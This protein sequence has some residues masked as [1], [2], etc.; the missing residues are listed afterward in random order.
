MPKNC[1]LCN[2]TISSHCMEDRCLGWQGPTLWPEGPLSCWAPMTSTAGNPDTSPY[3]VSRLSYCVNIGKEKGWEGICRMK[4]WM[5]TPQKDVATQKNASNTK[6]AHRM[7][8]KAADE[9]IKK[10]I[11]NVLKLEL[12]FYLPMDLI[13]CTFRCLQSISRDDTLE[14]TL[15]NSSFT[16]H[17]VHF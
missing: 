1:P 4:R 6:S 12:Q 13:C 10:P 15:P 8:T 17:E 11:L 3:R 5:N 16:R 14:S 7:T 2:L 9:G